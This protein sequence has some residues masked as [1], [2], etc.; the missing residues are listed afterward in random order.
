M[1]TQDLHAHEKFKI[2]EEVGEREVHE[3]TEL[4][5]KRATVRDNNA[6]RTYFVCPVSSTTLHPTEDLLAFLLP[7]LGPKLLE[8]RT[9]AVDQHKVLQLGL[10][11]HGEGRHSIQDVECG[12]RPLFPF[13]NTIV[14]GVAP[15]SGTEFE[16]DLYRNWL[17]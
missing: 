11:A 5:R 13:L 16:V 9:L 1:C 12:G 2:G 15:K 8:A 7:P 4:G 6:Y 10:T 14:G 3:N 17:R